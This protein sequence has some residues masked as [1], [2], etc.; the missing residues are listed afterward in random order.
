MIMS[1]TRITGTFEVGAGAVGEADIAISG[2]SPDQIAELFASESDVDT[3]L[4]YE[5]A[6]RV[7]DPEVG[8]LVS[9]TV[10]GVD[11]VRDG[12]HWVPSA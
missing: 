2:L 6:G 1:K 12:A 8:D 3:Q 9:F 11:Y 5:C 4:C 10:G 7:Q